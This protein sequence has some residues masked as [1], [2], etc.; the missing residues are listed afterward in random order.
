MLL[1]FC[2]N[3]YILAIDVYAVATLFVVITTFR[4]VRKLILVITEQNVVITT[5]TVATA[6]T[7][8]AKM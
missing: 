7:S 5:K 1:P 8:I 3:Y 2:N 4:P 6:L